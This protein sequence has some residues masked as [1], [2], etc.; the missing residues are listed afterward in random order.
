MSVTRP[1]PVDLDASTSGRPRH[2]ASS[3][4]CVVWTRAELV[5]LTRSTRAQ[6]MSTND[7]RS[8]NRAIARHAPCRCEVGRERRNP[9]HGKDREVCATVQVN[10]GT[11]YCIQ[12]AG[13]GSIRTSDPHLGKVAVSSLEVCSRPAKC[14]SVHPVSIASN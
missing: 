12:R 11:W 5:L 8:G 13:F 7:M 6:L 1:H 10:V 4:R 3:P 14:C 2:V 9:Q